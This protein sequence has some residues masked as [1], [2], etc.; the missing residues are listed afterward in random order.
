MSDTIELEHRNV[1]KDG[2]G[3]AADV[4]AVFLDL[5]APW[6]AIP[7]AKKAMAVGAIPSK[8]HLS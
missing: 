6:E 7:D 5:P 3:A 4:D 1:C 8:K 2:F